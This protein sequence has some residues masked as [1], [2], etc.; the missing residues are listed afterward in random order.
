MICHYSSHHYEDFY[1]QHDDFFIVSIVL[2]SILT[3]ESGDSREEINTLNII[4]KSE[5]LKSPV[6][7]QNAP[8]A[9]FFFTPKIAQLP[10]DYQ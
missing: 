1:M 4:C 8:E 3:C 6:K 10:V 9:P 7:N 5:N 2:S